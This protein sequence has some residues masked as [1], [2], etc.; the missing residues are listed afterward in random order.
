MKKKEQD[1]TISKALQYRGYSDITI[2]TTQGL[3]VVVEL[4]YAEDGDL[5]DACKEALKQ[6][7]EKKYAE[8]LMKE[9]RLKQVISYGIAFYKK[10]CM[11]VKGE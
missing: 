7:K 1:T 8:G 5:E 3:K 4:K 2:R 10:E 6:I 11:V 9:E